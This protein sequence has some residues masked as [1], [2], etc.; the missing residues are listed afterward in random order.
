MGNQEKVIF[1]ELISFNIIGAINTVV[2]YGL[3][4]L[5]L[6]IGLPYL[7]ALFLEYCVGMVISF[8]ANK[9]FTFRYKGKITPMVV[10]SM[11]SSYLLILGINS[12]LLVLFI[13]G[14]RW[15]PYAA[16]A[17]ALSIA[18]GLSFFAQKFVVF[19]SRKT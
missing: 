3:Y 1:R 11:I 6:F 17:V 16:Q 13:E 19:R 12:L 7:T 10:F 2:T 8:L 14:L 4:S 9:E 15:N 18:V 5:L